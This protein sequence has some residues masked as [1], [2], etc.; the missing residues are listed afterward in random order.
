MLILMSKRLREKLRQTSALVT[1]SQQRGWRRCRNYTC[2]IARARSWQRTGNQQRRIEQSRACSIW[3]S[4]WQ[5]PCLRGWF[6]S[7][8]L[9]VRPFLRL[10]QWVCQSLESLDASQGCLLWADELTDRMQNQAGVVELIRVTVAMRHTSRPQIKAQKR[11]TQPRATQ[12]PNRCKAWATGTRR[13]LP[14]ICSKTTPS[15]TRQSTE[16]PSSGLG[17]PAKLTWI[18]VKIA[19]WNPGITNWRRCSLK[20]SHRQPRASTPDLTL[21]WTFTAWNQEMRPGF[22]HQQKTCMISA[23]LT[24]SQSCPQFS[25]MSRRVNASLKL[26]LQTLVGFLTWSVAR[27]QGTRQRLSIPASTRCQ[28][29]QAQSRTGAAPM[30]SATPWSRE[31]QTQRMPAL[32]WERLGKLPPQT[33]LRIRDSRTTASTRLYVLAQTSSGPMPRPGL[34]S[35]LWPLISRIS[36]ASLTTKGRSAASRAWAT[37][38]DQ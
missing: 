10:S 27:G 38:G 28:T 34:A 12:G 20:D 16:A 1:L 24:T 18:M 33:Q 6:R 37:A 8:T 4:S 13:N 30:M 11:G 31:T 21:F 22:Q 3:R 17:R 35:T 26:G 32:F 36:R 29:T 23:L 25:P 5:N 15:F 2:P 14:S 19:L 9:R 7:L